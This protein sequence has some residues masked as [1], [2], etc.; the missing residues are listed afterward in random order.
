MSHGLFLVDSL[1]EQWKNSTM[2][3]YNSALFRKDCCALFSPREVDADPQDFLEPALVIRN[4]WV[5]ASDSR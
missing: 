1:P 5:Q 3:R 4:R 2:I